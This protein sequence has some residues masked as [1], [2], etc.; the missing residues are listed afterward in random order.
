MP[1]NLETAR[2]SC[3]SCVLVVALVGCAAPAAAQSVER[4]RPCSV[5]RVPSFRQLFTGTLR[6][7]KNVPS[8]GSFALLGAGALAAV[9]AH[10]VDGSV[11]R[12]L[13]DPSRLHEPLEPG[14]IIG[15]TPFQLGIAFATYG[16]GRSFG[17]TC[18]ANVGAD[19][20]R[21]QLMAEGLTM[22]MKQM[23]RRARPEG[24]G[25]SFPS[26]H[27]TAAFASATV[28]QQHFGWKVGVPAYGVASYVAAS[29]VQMKKHYL[30][31]VA[32]GAAL[33]IVAGRSVMLGRNGR[34]FEVAPMG[35][36][37]GGG[38]SFT[39]VDKHKQ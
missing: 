17:N 23:T 14:A 1:T 2:A 7:Y 28:L 20:V 22:A 31:D 39:W 5:A 19:L 38:A 33:G 9:G 15:S 10:S 4:S 13:E 8:T 24:S 11:T 34:G 21:V 18:A 29:R 27:T 36:A 16:I 35:A 12:A 32:F 37:G 26:G 30:S 3:L 25:F 6:D